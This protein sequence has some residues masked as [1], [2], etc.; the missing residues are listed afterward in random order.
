[1]KRFDQLDSHLNEPTIWVLLIVVFAAWNAGI[2]Y[3]ALR[4]LG[5]L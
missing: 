2:I 5:V 3:G 1:M 4:A